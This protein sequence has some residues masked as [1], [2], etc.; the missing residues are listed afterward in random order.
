MLHGHEVAAQLPA[1]ARGGNAHALASELVARIDELLGEQLDAILHHRRFQELESAWRGLRQLV[2]S[3]PRGSR[4]CRVALLNAS[5]AEITRD[6]E[7]ALEFDLSALFWHVYT[8]EF[9]MP[10]GEPL[11]VIICNYRVSH[12][13]AADLRAL[14]RVAA[15]AEA[16]FCVMLFPAGPELFGMDGFSDLHPSIKAQSLFRS[17]EYLSWRS[18]RDEPATRF[19]AFMMPRVLQRRPWAEQGLRR[20]RFPYRERVRS[21]DDYLWGHP[22]FAL[23][24]VLLREFDEVGWFAHVRGAPRDTLAGGIVTDLFPLRPVDACDEQFS[25]LPALELV[26]TDMMERELADCG[27]IVLSHCW[28][29]AYAAF[30]S[31]PSLYRL[32]LSERDEGADN[33]RIGAQLQNVLC[34][35]RF[36][37]YIKVMMRDKIGSYLTPQTCEQELRDWLNLYCAGGENLDWSTR[38]RFPLRSASVHVR[39]KPMS[40]GHML[41]NIA[42]SPHYQFDGLVG[43][44][45]LTTEIAR[46]TQVPA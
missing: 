24:S 9:D 19:L 12:R 45:N 29:T 30:L 10:G 34:A 38:A 23:A 17:E 35:S 33:E 44:I 14:R 16:A 22:G 42:L 11:G 18:L 28:Q 4:R 43:E 40:P 2:D 37:H 6:V 27:F 32:Q 5:W 31:L 3:M 36:A 13:N 25:T 20:A 39:E 7:R 41:C 26:V 8:T 1:C 21:T 46:G 15:V